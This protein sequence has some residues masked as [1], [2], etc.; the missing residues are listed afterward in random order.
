ML[1][2]LKILELRKQRHTNSKGHAKSEKKDV[3]NVK[4]LCQVLLLLDERATA[5]PI[6]ADSD[7]CSCC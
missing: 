7:V 5:D 1:M 6:A 3:T 2:A 4:I